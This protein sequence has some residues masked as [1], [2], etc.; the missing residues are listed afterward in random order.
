MTGSAFCDY[1]GCS[2][3]PKDS[4]FVPLERI[5]SEL[6]GYRADKG[7]NPLWRFPEITGTVKYQETS[8]FAFVGISGAVCALLRATEGAWLEMLSTV[9][10]GPHKVT[11][12]HLAVD[13]PVAGADYVLPLKAKY[14]ATVKLTRKSVRTR[15]MTEQGPDGRETGTFFAGDRKVNKV[16]AI[17]YDKAL[18]AMNKRAEYLP[19]TTRVEV[20]LKGDCV[21]PG[22]GMTLRDAVICDP[23]FYHYASPSLL[24]RPPE[25][26]QWIPGEDLNWESDWTP[27]DPLVR[28][29]RILWAFPEMARWVELADSTPGGRA[30]L[31]R[32]IAMRVNSYADPAECHEPPDTRAA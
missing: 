30:F 25:V 24:H 1:L 9:G 12:M 28:L 19:P 11:G 5:L 3:P 22:Q 18:E 6:G 23:A 32:Q 2:F 4:P 31:L 20:R 17:V 14:P 21:A 29:E 16:S 10:S 13:L 8:R 27:V 7:D 15:V 26:P